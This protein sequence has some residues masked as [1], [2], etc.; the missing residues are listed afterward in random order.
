MQLLKEIFR[1]AGLPQSGRTSFRTAVR[2]II[3]QQ[4]KLLMV[5]SPV[6]GDY[7]FPGGGLDGAED[8]AA[9]LKREVLEECGLRVSK[10]GPAFGKVIEYTFSED[11]GFE[12]FQMTSCYYFCQVDAELQPLRLDPYE[13]ELGFRPVWIDIQEAVQANTAVLQS[14]GREIPYWTA[15]ETFVLQQIQL[16]R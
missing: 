3:P 14:A 15:R 16:D 13:L 2:A 11:P 9:A 4:N 12:L 6:N 1:H 8:H 5:F 7:K 10:I